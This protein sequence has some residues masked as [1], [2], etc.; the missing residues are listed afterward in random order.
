VLVK[1]LFAVIAILPSLA[2]AD[3]Q[4]VKIWEGD[5]ALPVNGSAHVVEEADVSTPKHTGAT[6][7]VLVRTSMTTQRIHLVST[8]V[9][10]FDCLRATYT[11]QTGNVGP[12]PT[13][14]VKLPAELA[15]YQF[16]CHRSLASDARLSSFSGN[17]AIR[18]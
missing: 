18:S 1:Q 7:R 6:A 8:E 9:D 12:G 4:W 10:T 16:A 13:I 14:P 17:R 5:M 11:I 2:L 15:M 3:V